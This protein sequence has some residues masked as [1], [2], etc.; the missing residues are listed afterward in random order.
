[1]AGQLNKITPHRAEIL[2]ELARGCTI[3]QVATTLGIAATT[4][5]GTIEE[6]KATTG[7]RSAR[8]LGEWWRTWRGPW[9]MELAQM[10]GISAADLYRFMQMNPPGGVGR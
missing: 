1:M 10:G 9:L 6:I 7:C 3:P 8:E 4:V 5:R 2:R